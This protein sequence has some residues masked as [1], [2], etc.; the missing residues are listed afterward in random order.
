MAQLCA[1]QGR[2]D[3]A[4]DWFA[5]A[6][7]V[8]DEEGAG[9]LRAI[10]DFDE[11]LMYQRRSATGDSER[12]APLLDVALQQFRVL[13][14]TGWVKRA[15]G[16]QQRSRQPAVGS[17]QERSL[18][19]RPPGET[20]PEPRRTSRDEGSETREASFRKEGE[21]WSIS[22]DGAVFRLR[23]AKGLHYVAHLLR[24]P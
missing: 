3:E 10:V 17:G 1:L 2:Y 24:H 19:A 11:A 4:M 22:W 12:A 20:C 7:E 15:E 13:G 8:L 21:Y 6:R 18:Q 9:P 14:M 16:L 5:Q 23:D